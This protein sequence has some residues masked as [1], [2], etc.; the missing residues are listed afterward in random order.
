MGSAKLKGLQ[1]LFDRADATNN[2]PAP[3][4]VLTS[5]PV[6]DANKVSLFPLTTIRSVGPDHTPELVPNVDADAATSAAILNAI[7]SETRASDVPFAAV[8]VWCACVETCECDEVS[9]SANSPSPSPSPSQGDHLA[10]EF[11]RLTCGLDTSNLTPAMR[12]YLPLIDEVFF[13]HATHATHHTPHTMHFTP[14]A[15][16]LAPHTSH[17]APHRT[18][19][20]VFFKQAV[21]D[22][23]G[24]EV[25]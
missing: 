18:L 6:P 10:S 22:E 24:V 25:S 23:A 13:I 16:L 7:Q 15:S 14:H 12:L 5:L 3:E 11:I 19:R 8:Q 20:K 2:K 4:E 9:L 21:I 1:E 17:H